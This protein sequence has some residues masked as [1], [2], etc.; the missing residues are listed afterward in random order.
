MPP[1]K[2]NRRLSAEQKKTLERW[3]A[4]G[5]EYAPHWAFVAP[6]RP[7]EP[8]V[9]ARRLGAQADRPLR[10]RATRSRRAVA[11]ARGR[12]SHAHQAAVDRSDRAAADARGSRCV[13]RR[14]RSQRLR[15]ARRPPARQSAL[16]RTDG[17][18][19]ARC[20]PL[21]RQQRLSAGRRH[22]AMDLARLGREGHERRPAVRSVHDLA[23]GRRPAARCHDRP[24][25]RQRIQPQSSAERRRGRDSRRNSGSSICSTAST[26]RPRPG[27]A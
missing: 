26:P 12:S 20:R 15:E 4:E 24:E 11:V 13:R 14:P 19:V 6:Q 21:R 22:L 5:A 27:S 7:P 3:I 17:A 2:S 10:A 16:R 25:D 18:A 1:P 8:A 9:R 23:A